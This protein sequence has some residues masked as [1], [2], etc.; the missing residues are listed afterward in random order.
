MA[1]LVPDREAGNCLDLRELPGTGLQERGEKG[2]GPPSP[3][4]KSQS[5]PSR[6]GETM[7]RGKED[8]IPDVMEEDHQQ[9]E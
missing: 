9:T 1:S 6:D 2:P 4:K 8:S 3:S 7:R 5:E